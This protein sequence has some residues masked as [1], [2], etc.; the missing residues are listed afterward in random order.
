KWRGWWQRHTSSATSRELLP[1]AV[2]AVLCP[3]LITAKTITRLPDLW[4][5]TA[6][7]LSSL[8][9]YAYPLR[10]PEFTPRYTVAYFPRLYVL[11]IL[12]TLSCCANSMALQPFPRIPGPHSWTIGTG[13]A[14]DQVP[15]SSPCLFP[16]TIFRWTAIRSRRRPL[17]SLPDRWSL[18]SARSKVART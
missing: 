10:L 4:T 1:A 3:E 17:P 9:Y 16:A 2:D 7:S 12:D 15:K 5:A 18:P 6:G 13:P 14:G 8:F 11:T